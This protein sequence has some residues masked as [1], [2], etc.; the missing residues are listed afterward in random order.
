MKILKTVL[1]ILA[2]AFVAIQFMRPPRNVEAGDAALALGAL[3]AVPPDVQQMLETSCYDCHSNVTRYPWYAE[4]QPMGWW[5]N[6]HITDG[7]KHLNFSE[8]G[9]YRLQRQH[10]KFEEIVEMVNAGEMPLPSYTLAHWDATLTAEQRER[11][12]GWAQAMRTML[13]EKYADS[14]AAAR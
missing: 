8:F 9:T 11:L 6:S 4:I 5:L 1:I 7:K 3:Y 2:V 10:H 13:E 14:L 12:V